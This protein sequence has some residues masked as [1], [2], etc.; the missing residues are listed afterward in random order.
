MT[1]TERN[2]NQLAKYSFLPL[3][4]NIKLSRV[5]K[6]G[7]RRKKAI[8]LVVFIDLPDIAIMIVVAF[9]ICFY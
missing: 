9:F 3:N 6:K 8:R 1:I 7:L 2:L 4:L 5:S